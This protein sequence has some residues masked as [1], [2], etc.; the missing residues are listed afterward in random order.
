MRSIPTLAS[1]GLRIFQFFEVVENQPSPLLEIPWK[2]HEK[3]CPIDQGFLAAPAGVG[4][5]VNAPIPPLP[6]LI[7]KFARHMGPH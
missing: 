1:N 5:A 3:Q 4:L 6:S 7:Y 2:C